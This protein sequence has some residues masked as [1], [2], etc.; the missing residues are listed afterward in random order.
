[1]EK[2]SKF[3]EPVGNRS[4]GSSGGKVSQALQQKGVEEKPQMGSGK[5][6]EAQ[7]GS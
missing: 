5:S 3:R 6:A 2:H 4:N 7:K 1:M